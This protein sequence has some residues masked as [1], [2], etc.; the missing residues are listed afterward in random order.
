MVNSKIRLGVALTGT[1]VLAALAAASHVLAQAPA[2]TAPT[3]ANP[4]VN[5]APFPNPSE[6]VLGATAHGKL[7]VFAGLA[8]GW[9]PKAMVQEFDP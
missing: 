3:A 8:P 6:E 1:A 7:Y 5:L 2:P 9:K 4:W